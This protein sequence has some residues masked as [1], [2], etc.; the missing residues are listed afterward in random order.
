[1]EP[2]LVFTG[3]EGYGCVGSD[4]G[5]QILGSAVNGDCQSCFGKVWTNFC[6]DVKA[7]DAA[8]HIQN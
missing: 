4:G 6:C 5:A 3:N 2:F 1:M 8:F 7:I